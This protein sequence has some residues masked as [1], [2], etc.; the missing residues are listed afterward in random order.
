MKNKS[1]YSKIIF[2]SLALMILFVLIMG[3]VFLSQQYE[4]TQD[5][6]R[7]EHSAVIS[8]L[9]YAYEQLQDDYYRVLMPLFDTANSSTLKKLFGDTEK[10]NLYTLQQDL[11][12]LCDDI[13]LQEKRIQ[14]IYFYSADESRSYFYSALT[15][16]VE[17]LTLPMNVLPDPEY[18]YQRVTIGARR[19]NIRKSFSN[20][21]DV[22]VI[23]IQSP[24]LPLI[25]SG[26][27]PATRTVIFYSLD[28]FDDIVEKYRS[29]SSAR[30]YI[31]STDGI[32]LYD[33]AGEYAYN[34]STY[35]DY[36]SD[37]AENADVSSLTI[38]GVEYL[39][40]CTSSRRDSYH[41]GFL[42]SREAVFSG[43][44]R[45][46]HILLAV[47]L[48][49]C[50]LMSIVFLCSN[51]LI[52][53]RFAQIE[54]GMREIGHQRLDYRLPVD[55]RHSD[56]FTRIAH[57]FNQMCDELQDEIDH[58]YTYQMLQKTAEYKA[59]QTSI[60]PHFLYNSLEILRERL[61]ESAQSDCAEMVVLLSRFFEYQM[62]GE[63]IVNIQQ[64]LRALQ[65]YIELLSIKS[66]YIFEYSLEIDEKI[67]E[68]C[69]PKLILQ[70]LFE[71]Y[72]I[73]G[74]RSN[75]EDFIRIRGS[76]DASGKFIYIDFCDNGRG[77]EPERI[78]ALNETLKNVH[79]DETH[80]G[81]QNVNSRLRLM[82]GAEA[83]VVLL[84]NADNIGINVR[85]FFPKETE[86]LAFQP[87][88][89]TQSPEG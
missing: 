76:L 80:I 43:F 58:N 39:A 26:A 72:Y 20:G 61:E 46:S 19:L 81:L 9:A 21:F 70:P 29:V 13:C 83:G 15:R 6:A 31:T 68:A 18:P 50:V 44:R 64:E 25:D 42:V 59:L 17:K 3:A 48:A 67:K 63:S 53:Q 7:S 2:S 33:S 45:T 82:F 85:V 8:D 47:M 38:D 35:C 87:R 77:I 75:G 57:K 41:A 62:R 52:G 65:S 49:F 56:E 40:G 73:H 4:A 11:I 88:S 5:A 34:K 86:D 37:I 55:P 10:E 14:A 54:N 60:N 32:V 74:L 89:A 12:S 51:R 71:N 66:Q 79:P 28:G 84:P 30:Y 27:T 16:S 78:L 1:Y 23:G 69:V 24:S 22:N 36:F